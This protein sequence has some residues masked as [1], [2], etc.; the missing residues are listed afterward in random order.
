MRMPMK[1]HKRVCEALVLMALVLVGNVLCASA[2]ASDSMAIRIAWQLDPD[3]G[4]YLAQEHK[5]LEKAG[6]QPEYIKFLSAPSEFAA[7]QSK[8]VDIADMGLAPF[9]IGRAQGIPIEA[10]MIC[11]DVSGTNALV[12]QSDLNIRSAKD[13]KGLRIGAQRGTTAIYGLLEYLRR[14]GMG[15]NDVNVVDLSAPNIAPAFKGKEIDA[16]W[17]WSPWQ[18]IVVG[19]GGKRIITNKDIGAYAPQV[20]AVRSEWARENPEAL[21]KFIKVIGE[22]LKQNAANPE[23]GVQVVASTLNID[24]NT[25]RD[26]VKSSQSPTLDVQVSDTY[27][28]SLTAKDGLRL[29]IKRTTDFLR[30]AG[31]VSAEVN[32]NDLVNAEPL[33]KALGIK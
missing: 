19:M 33:K 27:P 2:H 9:V 7:L 8:S 15:A 31:I 16:T 25:A 30:S 23:L 12:V 20:W 6:L 21:Q 26:M 13:L 18:N 14:D 5:L 3:V 28:L 1:A 22:S 29:Q 17:V 11:V 10:V 4:L 32:P 24:Q